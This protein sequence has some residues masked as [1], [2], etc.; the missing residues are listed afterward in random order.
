MGHNDRLY[1]ESGVRLGA[2]S[3]RLWDTCMMTASVDAAEGA[4]FA[5]GDT[6]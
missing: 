4:C 6:S 1:R 2:S 5:V 3:G